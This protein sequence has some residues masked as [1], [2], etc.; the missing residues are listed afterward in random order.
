VLAN[1]YAMDIV[2]ES[3]GQAGKVQQLHDA[4]QWHS[5][6]WL[7]DTMGSV[8]EPAGWSCFCVPACSWLGSVSGYVHVWLLSSLSR[9]AL[10]T[11][12]R[13]LDLSARTHI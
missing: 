6:I 3:V 12:H 4:D 10:V 13:H 1:T 8:V 11:M 9:T 7:Y 2:A 5:C